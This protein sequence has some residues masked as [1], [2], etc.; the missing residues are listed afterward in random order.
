MCNCCVH[1][2]LSTYVCLFSDLQMS[3]PRALCISIHLFPHILRLWNMTV[4]RWFFYEA[5]RWRP[6]LREMAEGGA[7]S[8]GCQ[9]GRQAEAAMGEEGR[10]W[11]KRQALG[12]EPTWPLVIAWITWDPPRPAETVTLAFV[13][14]PTWVQPGLA[15]AQRPAPPTPEIFTSCILKFLKGLRTSCSLNLTA[16]RR[17]EAL[18]TKFPEYILWPC[19]ISSSH[20]P[21]RL[22]A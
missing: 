9:G 22:I 16:E 1:M 14:P 4:E 5:W 13:M 21:V 17:Q 15:S 10:R 20:Q 11:E 7:G 8:R 6:R 18:I 19:L 3:Q 2:A 12:R